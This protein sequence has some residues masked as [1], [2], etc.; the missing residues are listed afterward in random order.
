MLG[1]AGATSGGA[2]ATRQV[3]I[4]VLQLVNKRMPI[5]PSED[6]GA[7]ITKGSTKGGAKGGGGAVPPDMA[8]KA[9]GEPLDKGEIAQFGAKDAKVR[10]AF[11]KALGVAIVAAYEFDMR[12]R[13]QAS[14]SGLSLQSAIARSS[15]AK[16]FKST[17]K[18][19]KL[20]GGLKAAF[21][22]QK[23]GQS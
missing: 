13:A 22:A 6:D 19:G 5:E 15:L 14:A 12:A 2:V 7:N 11:L 4:G 8:A 20:K 21:V 9:K 16:S 10:E 23:L 1:V 3:C 18:R 17:Q